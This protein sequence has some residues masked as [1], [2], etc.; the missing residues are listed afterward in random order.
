M[1]WCCTPA[2][3]DGRLF[4][5]TWDRL[6]C[7]DLRMDERV[8]NADKAFGGGDAAVLGSLPGFRSCGTA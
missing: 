2:Y 3:A 1:G 8:V 6:A 5:R 7:Y 4:I